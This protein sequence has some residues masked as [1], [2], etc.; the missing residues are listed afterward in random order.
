MVAP[1]LQNPAE[2]TREEREGGRE[3]GGGGVE[4]EEFEKRKCFS[5]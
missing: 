5:F 2:Q 1:P 3:G 4:G